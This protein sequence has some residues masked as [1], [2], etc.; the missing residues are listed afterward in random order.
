M[1][2]FFESGWAF[3]IVALICY[4]SGFITKNS[5]ALGSVGSFWLVMAIIVRSKYSKKQAGQKTDDTT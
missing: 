4:A 3:M 2:K 1:R 5:L